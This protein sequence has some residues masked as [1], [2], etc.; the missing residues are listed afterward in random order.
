MG[1]TIED[2]YLMMRI[3][4][5]LPSAYGSLIENLEDILDSTFV[6]LT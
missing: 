5:N 3:M 2:E 4:I 1:T 6:P